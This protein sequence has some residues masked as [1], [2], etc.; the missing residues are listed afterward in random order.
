MVE[1]TE[2][3]ARC[4]LIAVPQLVDPN[5]Y[6]SVVLLIEHT[7]E[8]SMGIVVNRPLELNVGEFCESQ[9]M[10]FS[11]DDEEPIFQGGPVQTDR[12]FILHDSSQEGPETEVVM[13]DVRLSYSLESLGILAEDP[14]SRLRIFL[15]YAG[16]GEGQLADEVTA[17]SW[18]VCA[19]TPKLIFDVGPEEVWEES[20]RDMGIEPAQLMH[21]GA[22]H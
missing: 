7:S 3:D 2:L 14:P 16:W 17:G 4:L 8:G 13:D 22:V 15:G 21:S 6:R 19:A 20:L 11:G 10:S 18:L 12:A 9:S 5:F 1:E